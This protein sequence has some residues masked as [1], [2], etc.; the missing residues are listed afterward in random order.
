MR[1]CDSSKPALQAVERLMVA[2]AEGRLDS[3]TEKAINKLLD[4]AG[5]TETSGVEC[6]LVLT[7]DDR[8]FVLHDRKS[9]RS[10]KPKKGRHFDDKCKGPKN[11]HVQEVVP[12][13]YTRLSNSGCF[14]V[15]GEWVCW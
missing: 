14:W 15:G 2:V 9:S 12:L 11:S 3:R 8:T 6:A 7:S 10:S 4:D 1:K 5:I 13:A